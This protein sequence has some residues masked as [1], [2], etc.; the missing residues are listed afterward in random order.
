[1]RHECAGRAG[2]N[3]WTSLSPGTRASV[4]PYAAVRTAAAPVL[5]GSREHDRASPRAAAQGRHDAERS[6]HQAHTFTDA[7]D[8]HGSGCCLPTL[9]GHTI[10]PAAT[11]V[12]MLRAPLVRRHVRAGSAGTTTNE[13]AN[14]RHD[15]DDDGRA[16]EPL[17]AA[18]A[19]WAIRS[20]L[21]RPRT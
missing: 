7:G 5:H 8:A 15:T 14:R 17:A 20:R 10:T 9:A 3:P 12:E 2:S 13:S 4:E 19:R 18:T 21:L 1:M 6:G 16:W 11:G